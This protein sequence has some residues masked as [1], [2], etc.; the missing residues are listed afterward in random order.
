MA[1]TMREG[2]TEDLDPFVLRFLPSKGDMVDVR[3]DQ[4]D[5]IEHVSPHVPEDL[6]QSLAFRASITSC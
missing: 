4:Q 2:C 1:A 5:T 3:L 6:G